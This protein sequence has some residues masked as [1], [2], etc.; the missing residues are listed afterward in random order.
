MHAFTNLKIVSLTLTAAIVAV[1][2][3]ISFRQIQSDENR[4][5]RF[6]APSLEDATTT[7]RVRAQ[8]DA[9]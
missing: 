2:L 7:L 6:T 5:N 9:P 3:A 8:A 1:I 4:S